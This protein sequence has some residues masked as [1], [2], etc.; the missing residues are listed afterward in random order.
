MQPPRAS[1]YENLHLG[2]SARDS[3][4]EFGLPLLLR[5]SGREPL[6]MRDYWANRQPY[7]CHFPEGTS[8][9]PGPGTPGHWCVSSSGNLHSSDLGAAPPTARRKRASHESSILGPSCWPLHSDPAVPGLVYGT[10]IHHLLKSQTE[11]PAL[12]LS[13]LHT[14]N[15]H[16]QVL[17]PPPNPSSTLSFSSSLL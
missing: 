9:S 7:L 15:I 1:A 10:A 14:R 16:Q 6:A 5:P 4:S 2:Q 8:P 17:F 13:P 3:R 12:V 11:G